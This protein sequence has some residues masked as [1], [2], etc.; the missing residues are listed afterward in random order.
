M[1]CRSGVTTTRRSSA[2]SR[3]DSRTLA[4][5]NIDTTVA[6]TSLTKTAATGP[7]SATM[8]ASPTSVD[9]AASA[10]WKRKPVV[11]SYWEAPADAFE[12]P[13]ALRDWLELA[14]GAALRAAAERSA[15][16]PRKP[17]KPR[18]SG[19]R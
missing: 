18:S 15:R 7:P 11:M 2:S 12:D 13:Q 8:P 4:W 1:R 16:K 3:G 17:R 19:R 6:H 10:G 5:V 9:R 14:H